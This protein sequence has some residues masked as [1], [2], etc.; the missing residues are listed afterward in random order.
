MYREQMGFIG[1]WGIPI[2]ITF[3]IIQISSFSPFCC[4]LHSCYGVILSGSYFFWHSKIELLK[5]YR[6]EHYN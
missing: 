2:L 6:A 3:K 5:C 1:G 4:E